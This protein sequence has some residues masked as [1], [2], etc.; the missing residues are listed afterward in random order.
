[1]T[2]FPFSLSPVRLS[3]QDFLPQIEPRFLAFSACSYVAAMA[4]MYVSLSIGLPRPYWVLMTAYVTTQPLSGPM[5]PKMLHRLGGV[6]LGAAVATVLTPALVNAPFQLSLGLAIWIG[7]CVYFAVLDR[8]PR[9]FVFMLAGYTAAVIGFPYVDDPGD[10][11]AIALAR[12]VEMGL[13]IVFATVLHSVLLPLNITRVLERRVSTFLSDTGFWIADAFRGRHGFR[14]ERKRGR[15]A[16]DI[17]ELDILAFHLPPNARQP[18]P[19]QCLV[20]ALQGRLSLL[21]PLASATADRLDALRA[22]NALPAAVA[23]LV[24]DV[25]TWLSAARPAAARL[26]E[27]LQARCRALTGQCAES[28]ATWDTLLAGSLCQRLGEF[29]A[30]HQQAQDLA[31]H[32]RGRGAEQDGLESELVRCAEPSRRHQ[33]QS[34]AVCRGC[35]PSYPC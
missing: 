8:T 35:Q 2:A 27:T 34:L 21:I 9:A 28:T 29:I 6:L 32:L 31:Q 1:M 11:F 12:M 7:V 22:R 25:V 30:A 23:D 13:A 16:A 19:T 20:S 15:L 18:A 17:S 14:E 5:R 33:Q 4:A 24:D 10:I 26:A 3:A